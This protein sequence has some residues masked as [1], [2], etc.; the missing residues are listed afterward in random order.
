MLQSLGIG[1]L[2]GLIRKSNGVE[3]GSTVANDELASAIT[4]GESSDYNPNEDEVNDGE[5]VDDTLVEKTVK[6]SRRKKAAVKKTSKRK[7]RFEHTAP[8]APGRVHELDVKARK[9][10]LET[11]QP[12]AR[13]TRQKPNPQTVP[14]HQESPL[15]RDRESSLQLD[16]ELL[17]MQEDTSVRLDLCPLVD[18][19]EPLDSPVISE[20]PQQSMAD[21]GKTGSGLN[22]L[23]RMLGAKVR[24]EISPGMKRPEKPVLA[25]KLA[26]EGGLVARTHMP[27]LPHF[28]E[29]KKDKNLVKD[30]IGKVAKEERKGEVLSAIDMF[31][32]TH[33]S[34]KDGFS[35]PVKEAIAKMEEMMVVPDG[36]APKS[37]VAV[38]AEVLTAKSKF[39]KNVGMQPTSSNKSSKSN[40]SVSAHVLDL[41]EK[42]E[43]SQ[44]QAEE[45]REEM[46][47]MKKKAEEAEAAQAERDKSY[48]LLLKRTEE[49]DARYMQM[50]ALL[51]GK[52][53]GN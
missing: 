41:E 34:K 11:D 26:S 45:M 30:Y 16:G 7:K 37:A 23:T 9:R 53:T 4:Q 28:K 39:L 32:A 43:K 18:K 29:Y 6:K 22:K 46:N 40:A 8:M 3:E 27:V 52:S 50:M 15:H 10:L 44:Q 1:A 47:A 2:V 42:L 5:E 51:Q 21:E 48:Q 13:V 12:P 14:I 33:H 35:K 36:E 31:K 20:E 19:N 49:N 24:I 38:V 17:S 25:A